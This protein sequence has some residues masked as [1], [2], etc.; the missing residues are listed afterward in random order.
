M[1]DSS[2]MNIKKLA[3]ICGVSVA[4]VSRV[5]NEKG[6]V[7]EE[8]KE[9]ILKIIEELDYVPNALARNLSRNESDVIGVIVPDVSNAFYIEVIK[10]VM[11]E[12]SN[13]N[14]NIVFFN[15]DGD[16]Q[17]ELKAMK[18]LREQRIKGML[19]IS[20]VKKY[21]VDILRKSIKNLDIPLILLNKYIE[22]LNYDGVFTDDIMAGYLLTE[23]LINNKHKDITI[24]TGAENS[25]VASNRVRGYKNAH[26]DYGLEIKDENIIYTDFNNVETAYRIV[27]KLAVEGKLPKAIIAGNLNI[28]LACIKV[29]NEFNIKMGE[30]ISFVAFDDIKIL[31]ELG[32]KVT[33]VSQNPNEMGQ[34]AFKLL[35]NR[36]KDKNSSIN[37]I[38]IV[39]ELII[40]GSEKIKNKMEVL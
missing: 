5:I 15:S 33:V 40:R 6:N 31:Y 26:R 13:N 27:R 21:E 34:Q 24:L 14:L 22:N 3:S 18:M 12:A 11:L 36:L 35:I 30:D 25:I 28:N 37:K 38:H 29:F 7:K 9:K 1:V 8:T 2:T 32:I 4:T 20:A 23:V 17:K 10:G 39:P 19:L 16:I